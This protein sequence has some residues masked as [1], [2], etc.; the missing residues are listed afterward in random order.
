MN[1]KNLPKI[2]KNILIVME[3][4]QNNR[5]IYINYIQMEKKLQKKDVIPADRC[6]Q[7]SIDILPKENRKMIGE[8]C[9]IMFTKIIQWISTGG[10]NDHS[11]KK[12]IHLFIIKLINQWMWTL[13][14]HGM[15]CILK[16]IFFN[17]PLKKYSLFPNVISEKT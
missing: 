16:M 3:H 12:T 8:K 11:C 10:W 5:L 6:H 13:S 14:V 9:I 7:K 1:I 17:I 2:T 4:I 15:I